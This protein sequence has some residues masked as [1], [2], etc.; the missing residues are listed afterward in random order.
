METDLRLEIKTI[1]SSAYDMQKL[2]IQTGLRIVANF[3]V[4][5]GQEPGDD[6]NELSPEA[7]NLLAS[8]R[9]SYKRITDGLMKED[10]KMKRMP[11][12]FPADGLITDY[13]HYALLRSYEMLLEN[14]ETLFKDLAKVV[15]KHPMWDS[16]FDKVRGCGPAVAG[17][18]I[19]EVDIT[20]SKYPSSLWRLSGLDVGPDGRGRSKR[21]EH[22]IEREYQAADGQIKT[23]MSITYKPFLK[24]KLIAIFGRGLVMAGGHYRTV[25]DN[26]K[27]RI[28]TDPKRSELTPAH[29]HA[30][31]V[32][33]AV[34]IFLKD[35][36]YV[37]RDM[38]GLETYLTYH[39][40]VQGHIH[41]SPSC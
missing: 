4:K 22:L 14:E 28:T 8:L 17:V 27:H 37:W 34:K 18:I 31:S 6:E 2:R 33:Y 40:G 16:F 35:M 25:Y 41:N 23:K 11:T 3:K 24:T 10:G 12:I 32:R 20:K 7:T 19:S 1:V 36:Y 21:K 13:A 9:A 15:K 29:I 30:M 26:Y 38:M 5:L 39:E